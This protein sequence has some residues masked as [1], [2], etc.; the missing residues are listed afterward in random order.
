MPLLHPGVT[1]VTVDGVGLRTLKL[2]HGNRE[3]T[4]ESF[5]DVAEAD[6]S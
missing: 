3:L 6:Q 5:L 1:H 4:L 2:M